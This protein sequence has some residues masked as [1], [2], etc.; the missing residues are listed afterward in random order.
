[1]GVDALT[2]KEN[3]MSKPKETLTQWQTRNALEKMAAQ[4]AT[5]KLEQGKKK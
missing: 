2:T 4:K 3:K 5:R 1:L